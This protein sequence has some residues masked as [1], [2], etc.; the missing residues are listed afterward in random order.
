V[1]TPRLV[2]LI[3]LTFGPGCSEG[4]PPEPRKS[5]Q[6]SDF[7]TIQFAGEKVVIPFRGGIRTSPI[8][9]LEVGYVPKAGDEIVLTDAGDGEV[10]AA[11]DLEALEFYHSSP[12]PDQLGQFRALGD[13]GRLFIVARGTVGSVERVIDGALPLELRAVELR[14]PG[15]KSGI[16]WVSESFARRLSETSVR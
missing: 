5:Y 4:P 6:L 12:G 11:R 10:F 13:E 8:P 3:V 16:A 1:P 15:Q 14:L 9:E 2:A 7:R